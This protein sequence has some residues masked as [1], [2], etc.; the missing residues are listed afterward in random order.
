MSAVP[1][2]LPPMFPVSPWSTE[3]IE[4]LY[5]VF[6]R[7]FVR[8]PAHYCGQQ[9]W[10]FPEKERGKELIFWHMVEREDPPNSG[11]RVADFRRSERLPWARPMLDNIGQPEILNWDYEEGDGD[12]HTY[13][14]LKDFDYLIVMK[15]YKDGRR[16][17]IT[18]HWVE[19]KNK[20]Q[21]LQKKYAK[22]LI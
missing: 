5:A 10:F 18:A 20:R 2:W 9:V 12:I 1:A 13:V 6:V 15:R 21:K 19:Y 8:N 22:R 3:L 16:R 11:N 14:W 4:S 7:D 17:L